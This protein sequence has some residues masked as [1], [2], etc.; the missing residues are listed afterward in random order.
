MLVYGIRCS[1]ADLPALPASDARADY[2]LDYGLLIFPDYTRTTCVNSHGNITAAF[3]DKV[4]RIVGSPRQ[5]HEVSHEHPYIT[6]D[7]DEVVHTLQDSY[8]T[9]Q[10]TWYYVPQVIF[11]TPDDLPTLEV[12]DLN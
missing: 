12:S 1:P 7:E 10:P 4:A 6:E 2:Y 11:T 9:L 8:P 5:P 3:W